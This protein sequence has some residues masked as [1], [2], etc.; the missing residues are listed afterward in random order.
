VTASELPAPPEEAAPADLRV[1]LSPGV[2]VLDA[3]RTL[4]GGHPFRRLSLTQAG[5]AAIGDW[6]DTSAVGPGQGR[7]RLAR[8]LLDADILQPRPAPS[9]GISD[10]TLVVPVRDRA[11]ELERCL[12]AARRACPHAPIIV[13]DDGSTPALTVSR[14]G[15]QVLRHPTSRGPA[16][17]RNTGLAACRTPFVAFVDSDVV[18]TASAVSRL[19]DHLADPCVA[20]VAPRVRAQAPAG[21]LVAA[22]EARHSALDMGPSA[23]VVA[24]GRPLSYVP[25]TA[26]VARREA[27]GAGFD[28]SLLIGEDVDLVWRLADAGW[29]IRYEPTAEV[30]HDHPEALARFV[31][32]RRLYARSIGMLAR[33][34]PRAVPA[35]WVSPPL[36]L[37]WLLLLGGRPRAAGAAVA[38]AVMRTER[39]LGG[40][41]TQR[42][43]IACT[44]VGRGLL[45][46]GV[47]L[48]HAVRRAWAPP[49]VALCPGRPRLRVALL[50][51]FA[52]PVV[53]DAVTTRSVRR[54]L[55]DLPM[56]LLD[57]AVAVAGTWE[58]CLEQR[59]VRPLL[60]AWYRA[61]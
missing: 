26:L 22:Y 24:P 60:P 40:R 35:M 42:R 45:V 59:T 13:V 30:R 2:R 1:V 53:E 11:A 37:P 9:R 27:L 49:L 36:V 50:L 38:W 31:A 20:V 15:V 4:L 7:R 12:D 3:G 47:A 34:H 57:E 5:A 23:A 18:I 32:R 28:E 25:S 52:V 58:G 19:V 21:S 55:G 56:R 6:R 61:A 10:L 8:R 33:R 14:S 48:A 51:A 39:R 41:S 29:R 46:T 44:V 16:A 43:R 17:A 54:A